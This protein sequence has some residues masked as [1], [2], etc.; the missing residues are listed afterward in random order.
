MHT[1][2]YVTWIFVGVYPTQAILFFR[3][4]GC[5]KRIS[6]FFLWICGTHAN[7][8][9]Q[10]SIWNRDDTKPPSSSWWSSL[11]VCDVSNPFTFLGI[12][13]VCVQYFKLVLVRMY[14]MHVQLYNL[15]SIC[16]FVHQYHH[17]FWNFLEFPSE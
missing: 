17:L 2:T 16:A 1:N 6:F 5:E 9:N 7:V 10:P 3:Q 11:R 12:S 4:R 13:C 8:E 14:F 15:E